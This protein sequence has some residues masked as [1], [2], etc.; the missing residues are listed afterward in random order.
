MKLPKRDVLLLCQLRK[1]AREPLTNMSRETRIP[2][3]TLY[4]RLRHF[5]RS[6]VIRKHTSLIDFSIFGYSVK[7]YFQLKTKPS[8]RNKIRVYLTN[9]Q[10][11]NNLYRV[12]NNCDFIAEGIFRTIT[13]CE[14]FVDELDE[15]FELKSIETYYVIQEIKREGFLSNKQLLPI[16]IKK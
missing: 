14:D 9:H 4:D 5:E 11:I 7:A 15:R 16:L 3:S 2:V 12:N 10:N 13:E 1:N 6:S 8:A